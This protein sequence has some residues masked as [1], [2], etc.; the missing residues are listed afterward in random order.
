MNRRS[1][2]NVIIFLITNTLFVG[3][4]K[5]GALNGTVLYEL[6]LPSRTSVQFGYAGGGQVAAF[7]YGPD[8]NDHALLWS[9]TPTAVDLSPSIPGIANSS[10]VQ[11]YA[12]APAG[13][14]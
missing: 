2:K 12:C 13:F 6:A 1:C 14:T 4:A 8:F 9:G 3:R 7:G 11:G 10:P 5:G